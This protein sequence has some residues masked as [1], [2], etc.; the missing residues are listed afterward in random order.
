MADKLATQRRPVSNLSSGNG[1]AGSVKNLT[2]YYTCTAALSANDTI[3]LG[4]VPSNA[5][6]LGSSTMY[7]DDLAT[8]GSPTID[9]G[10]FAVNGNITDDD[11]A[12]TDGSSLAS[13]STGT[14]V[15]KSIVNYGLPAWDFVNGQSTD[16]GGEFIVRA[17]V[18]D[19]ATTSTTGS[20]AFELYYTID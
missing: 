7:W 5:R 17:T 9:I 12:L 19:A 13:A 20:L 18:K 6:I 4:R 3:T 11:D 1:L 10:L 15:V 8:S 2:A 16:P 14:K